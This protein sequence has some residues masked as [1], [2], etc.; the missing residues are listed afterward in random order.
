[1]MNDIMYNKSEIIRRCLQRVD[2]EY[3]ASG[4]TKKSKAGSFT[5]R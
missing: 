5:L 4:K 3:E 1:M 2:E